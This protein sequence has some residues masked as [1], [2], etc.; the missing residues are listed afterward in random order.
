ME[1]Y[2]IKVFLEV[3]RLL[4]FT[5]A[6][7][8][9]NLT[10]PAVSAKIKSLET[11]VG[12][13]L[14]YRLGR[15]IQL[16][17]V[18]Q[19]LYEEG[20]QLI[21]VENQLLSKI[22]EIKEG[23]LGCL[24]IGCT[25]AIANGWLPDVL[26]QYRQLFP[27][28]QTNSFVFDSAELLYRAIT[29][30]QVD[31]GFSDISFEEFTEIFSIPIDCIEYCLFAATNHPQ[32][33]QGWLSLKQL[34]NECCT[35]L[36]SGSPS[37]LVFE[38]RLAELGFDLSTFAQVET[39]DTA[40]LMRTYIL[41][42]NYLGFA[43]NFD[44]KTELD[45]KQLFKIPLQEFALLGNVSLLLSHRLSQS[46][47]TLTP[48][49]RRSQATNPI[50]KFVELVQSRQLLSP[51]LVA[52]KATQ[53]DSVP[54]T[55]ATNQSMR[56]RSPLLTQPTSLQRPETLTLRIGIQNGTIPTVTAGLII[57]QLSLLEH[58]LPRNGRYS[59]TQYQLQWCDFS[60][61][62]PIINGL[63]SGQLD[64]G[65]LGDYP[66]LLSALQPNNSKIL[67]HQTRLVS[68]VSTNPDGSCN[69]VIVPNKSHLQ[70]IEDLRGRVIAVPFS[71]SAH[72][73]VM[74]SLNS[75]NLLTEVKL[76]SL[77]HT[78]LTHLLNQAL[79]QADGYAHFAP[80]HD[81]ACR[82]GNFRYLAGSNIEHLPAFHGVVVSETLATQY[83]EVIIA[84]LRA[85]VAAQ[86]WYAN[87]PSALSVISA[88]TAL[89]S[90]IIAQILTN[91]EPANQAG[92]F[93]SDMSIR[94]DWIEQHI[95]Q[96]KLIP[97]NEQLGTIDL[98]HW[99]QSEFLQTVRHG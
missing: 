2:Q 89:E 56:L 16:T 93:F 52:S 33:H 76:A 57:Q 78:N 77:E 80:F 26:F 20:P 37:R 5:E 71:S 1:V 27:G 99:I 60:T 95:A 55:Q 36:P 15:K 3:A 51:K 61:G 28:I 45:A 75:A 17:E 32:V 72:G 30:N 22:E 49:V 14:F 85:L 65:I 12:T 29:D 31:I 7:D 48:P 50:Q 79:Q 96:L 68:F 35:L 10:Q 25:A 94:E 8:A 91:F 42:G 70:S 97:G 21:K 83:P 24:K 63:H 67:T 54:L 4:S 66:L 92:R 58:F 62:A 64:I 19:F 46:V 13:P 69:A 81:I 9:L 74:R 88:W 82:N 90:E 18:G 59:A 40:S 98:N 41:Q 73:M 86:Y 44:F 84:Y 53:T 6:A 43:S 38:S 47:M 87:T 11:E 23:K 39:V 34:Q